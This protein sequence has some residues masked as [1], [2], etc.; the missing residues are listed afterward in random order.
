MI[1]LRYGLC[2]L[3]KVVICL[4]ALYG[5]WRLYEDYDAQ[6]R[7]RRE[8]LAQFSGEALEI[9]FGDRFSFFSPLSRKIMQLTRAQLDSGVLFVPVKNKS[10]RPV[11]GVVQIT[12][13]GQRVWHWFVLPQ[14][15]QVYRVPT[16]HVPLPAP[17]ASPSLFVQRE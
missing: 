10:E 4:V 15:L 1:M 5:G 17:P 6:Q 13:R 7:A 3:V 14:E 8:L 9:N 16:T 11:L 2:G 12:P